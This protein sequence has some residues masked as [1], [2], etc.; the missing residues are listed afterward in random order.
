MEKIRTGLPELFKPSRVQKNLRK[1]KFLE[2]KFGRD[3]IVELDKVLSIK[4]KRKI[5]G[6]KLD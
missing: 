3:S 1:T 6:D 5:L 2:S 4:L